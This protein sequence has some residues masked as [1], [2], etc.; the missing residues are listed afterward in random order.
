MNERTRKRGREREG[1]RRN[2]LRELRSMGTECGG[3]ARSSHLD[4]SIYTGR[5]IKRDTANYM[6]NFDVL[7]MIN[8]AY[9]KGVSI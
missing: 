4:E 1:S 7:R 6:Y 3:R 9:V 8:G 5:Y 2:T